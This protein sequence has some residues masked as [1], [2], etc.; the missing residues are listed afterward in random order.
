[1]DK[2]YLLPVNN[3]IY[4]HLQILFNIASLPKTCESAELLC[5]NQLVLEFFLIN[6]SKVTLIT[7]KIYRKN[8][9]SAFCCYVMNHN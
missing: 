7:L 8:F 3:F 2:T 1:M 5:A 4:L 9:T 6:V